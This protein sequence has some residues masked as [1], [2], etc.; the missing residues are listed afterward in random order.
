MNYNNFHNEERMEDLLEVES[1]LS[2]NFNN[3]QLLNIALI[4]SSFTREQELDR[5]FCNE[6]MEFL[7]DGIFNAIIVAHLFHEEPES[8]EG[9]LSRKKSMLINE[10]SLAKVGRR[11]NI[12][13]YIL[14]GQ[15]LMNTNHKGQTAIIADAMEAI[16]GAIYL[17]K[18]FLEAQNFVLFHFKSNIECVMELKETRDAKSHLQEEM[19]KL[20]RKIP[21]YK[22]VKSR[23]PNHEKE[24]LVEVWEGDMKIAESWGKSKK[25]ASINAAQEALKSLKISNK[26]EYMECIL[27]E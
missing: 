26:K 2:V 16:I 5:K 25:Q 18:G 13:P 6:R 20:G 22:A 23:G 19:S 24:F 4:H 11:L 8:E 27:K 3:K 15:G 9:A 21:T 17:D 7:G 1:I 12:L 10:N 14:R